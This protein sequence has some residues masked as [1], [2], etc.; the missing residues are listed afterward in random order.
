[1]SSLLTQCGVGFGG[2]K[3]LLPC[4]WVHNKQKRSS[5]DV[6][7]H[8]PGKAPSGLQAGTSQPGTLHS[9]SFMISFCPST[10][11]QPGHLCGF[12]VRWSRES[13]HSSRVPPCAGTQNTEGRMPAA[14]S[15]TGAAPAGDMAMAVP[16]TGAP[17]STDSTQLPWA[18]HSR[19]LT[20]ICHQRCHCP[21]GTA[22]DKASHGP[23]KIP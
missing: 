17:G 21:A 12:Q 18:Q 4:L 20:W 14:Q 7:E 22:G 19:C 10:N 13:L 1:M 3:E 9:S 11:P 6:W 23:W 8:H 5:C 2:G 15:S 16:G